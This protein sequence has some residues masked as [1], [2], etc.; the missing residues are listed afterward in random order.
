MGFRNDAYA[1]VWDISETKSGG[2]ALR[3]SISRKDKDGTYKQDFSGSCFLYG[4][5]AE[6]ADKLQRRDRIK[7]LRTDVTNVYNKDTQTE[8]VFYK[9]YDFELLDASP[10]ASSE[11]TKAKGTTHFW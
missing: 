10:A 4:D 3:L 11:E 2:H 5:A 6:K 7:L 9:V 8:K 1:T